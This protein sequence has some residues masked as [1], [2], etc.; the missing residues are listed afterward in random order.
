MLEPEEDVEAGAAA[1]EDVGAG[2]DS[3]V[4]LTSVTFA[5][6]KGSRDWNSERKM[7]K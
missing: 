3:I 2:C 5:V 1:E 6:L 7:D 4:Q